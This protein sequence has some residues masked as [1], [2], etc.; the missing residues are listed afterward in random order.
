MTTEYSEGLFL[1]LMRSE[2]DQD[3]DWFL[4]FG[5]LGEYAKKC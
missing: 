2:I 1:H 5:V 3:R 4:I